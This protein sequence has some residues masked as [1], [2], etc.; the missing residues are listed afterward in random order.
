M[1]KIDYI[2]LHSRNVKDE[3]KDL[4]TEEIK[5]RLAK[6]SFPYAVCFEH[7]QGDF[8]MSTGIRNANAFNAREV[9]YLG[10]RK[11]DKRGS[12][13]THHYAD[14]KHLATIE[15]LKALKNKY[16]FYG[17]DNVGVTTPLS[18]IRWGLSVPL[19][20]A[21]GTSPLMI[22]GEEGKGLTEETLALCDVVVEIPMFGSV[23]SLN[24]GTAS[25]IVMND[26]V[27]K[28]LIHG[29]LRSKNDT[30]R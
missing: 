27:N 16:L 23:R 26:F 4:S 24:C 29:P 22:F 1:D 28:Y 21:Y 3:Y 5:E 12:V 7:W 19:Q 8:N 6:T 14:V 2:E 18:K 20:Y 10:K 15:D 9:F 30:N 11:W 17:I 25:G 13:G